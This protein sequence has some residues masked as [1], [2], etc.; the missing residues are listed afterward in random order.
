MPFHQ[1]FCKN[2][3][4]QL[5]NITACAENKSKRRLIY[6]KMKNKIP[7]SMMQLL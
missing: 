6:Q 5:Q 4:V 1:Y 2:T 7:D 3:S